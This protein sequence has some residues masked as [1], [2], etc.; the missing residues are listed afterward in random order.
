MLRDMTS[1]IVIKQG[2]PWRKR[3]V[4]RKVVVFQ[5]KCVICAAW[6][7]AERPTRR[8]CS[9]RCRQAAKRKRDRRA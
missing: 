8:Y 7:E 6:V 9:A 5:R 3:T 2:G 4:W 1:T